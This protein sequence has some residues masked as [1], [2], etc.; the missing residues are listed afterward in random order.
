MTDVTF[1][2]VAVAVGAQTGFGS[3]N[4]SVRDVVQGTGSGTAGALNLEDG[5]VLG[6][7]E[8]GDAESGIVIPSIVGIHRAVSPV[9]ASFTESADAFQRAEVNGF[10]ISWVHQGNGDTPAP[11]VGDADLSVIIPGLEAILESAGLVGVV[12]SAGVEQDYT[13]RHSGSAAPGSTVYSTWKIWH[14]TLAFVFTD[15]LVESLEFAFTPGGNCIVTA[16]ILV[17]TFNHVT[18]VGGFTFPTLEYDVM[19]SLAGPIVE[20]VGFDL[21]GQV[22]GF[23]NLTITIANEIDKFGDSNVDV[24]GQRQS[25]LKRIISL[26]GTFYVES[27]SDDVTFLNLRS[28]TAPTVGCFF[29]VGTPGATPI[30]AFKVEAHNLQAKD[31]KYN[32]IGSVLAVEINDAK[33]TATVPGG[34]FQL[35]MN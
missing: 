13:P 11:A 22:R 12:G 24:T 3:P 1:G 32:R 6:D 23:E 29:Q 5:I 10:A 30:N 8:S 7:A 21:Y 27:D 31:I 17:G 35:T 20:G 9:A 15:C 14:G 33:A 4:T 34:E 16:N 2:G 18:T 26:S 28:A 25:Q 19:A